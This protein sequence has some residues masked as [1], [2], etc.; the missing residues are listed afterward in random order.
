[1]NVYTIAR[2][3][4][5]MRILV[6]F[7]YRTTLRRYVIVQSSTLDPTAG[8]TQASVRIIAQNAYH[9]CSVCSVNLVTRVS[10]AKPCVPS[11]AKTALA[12]QHRNAQCVWTTPFGVITVNAYANRIG[13]VLHV[14]STQANVIPNVI[15]LQ[16]ET[17]Q[18]RTIVN[19]VC[20]MQSRMTMENENARMDGVVVIAQ[21]TS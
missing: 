17:A 12:S 1:M 13:S 3:V 16:D 19:N 18:H 14:K 9:I 7:V 2:R 21:S 20:Q 8:L 10:N 6:H 5:L 15:L 4:T 11:T